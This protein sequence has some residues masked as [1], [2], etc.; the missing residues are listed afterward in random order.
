MP[1]D[2][3]V[4][5]Q[6]WLAEKSDVWLVHLLGRITRSVKDSRE[7]GRKFGIVD[8]IRQS[9]NRRQGSTLMAADDLSSFA[10]NEK[11]EAA[12]EHAV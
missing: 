11:P 10:P 1:A 12:F 6:E 8:Q 2:P 7:A 4:V 3:A 9:A 5:N